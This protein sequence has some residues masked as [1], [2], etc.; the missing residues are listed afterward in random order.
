[1]AAPT[2]GWK[3]S[4]CI[5]ACEKPGCLLVWALGWLGVGLAMG[6][7]G[8]T[9]LCCSKPCP[10]L[11]LLCSMVEVTAVMVVG[12]MQP[13]CSCT[14]QGKFAVRAMV[15]PVQ[16]AKQRRGCLGF[17]ATGNAKTQGLVMDSNSVPTP[18]GGYA[19]GPTLWWGLWSGTPSPPCTSSTHY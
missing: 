6:V 17:D 8:V 11:T 14:C 1:M 5:S 13:L 9:T 19:R 10:G 2:L 16:L 7:W 15:P 4:G 18:C 12:L 3:A